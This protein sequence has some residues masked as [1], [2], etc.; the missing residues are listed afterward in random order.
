MRSS[1]RTSANCE[2]SLTET[3]RAIRSKRIERMRNNRQQ[4]RAKLIRAND[5]K[6][7]LDGYDGD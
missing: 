2:P 4:K 5:S 1:W 3:V 7:S 6:G